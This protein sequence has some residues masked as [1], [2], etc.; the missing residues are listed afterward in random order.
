[1]PALPKLGDGAGEEGT[2]EILRNL[3]AEDPARA[4]RQVHGA[5]EVHVE[6]DGV[7]HGGHGDDQPVVVLIVIKDR[8]DQQIEPVG[9]QNL[10]YQAIAHPLK[11]QQKILVAQ[12]RGIPQLLGRLLIAADGPL[13]KQGKEAEIEGQAEEIAVGGNLL[14]VDVKEVGGRLHGVKGDAD[15]Q[16]EVGNA[17]RNGK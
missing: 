15:G 16:Q 7:A 4:H 1:M 5:G 13:H 12:R 2:L 14:A 17:Q 11:A 8:L 6:L 3:K 10:F 9:H